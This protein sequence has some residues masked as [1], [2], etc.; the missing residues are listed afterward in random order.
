[1]SDSSDNSCIFIR[2]DER[3]QCK[4][5]NCI[6]GTGYIVH[7]EECDAYGLKA[8]NG[9]RKETYLVDG[10]G[11]KGSAILTYILEKGHTH[12]QCGIPDRDSKFTINSVLDQRSQMYWFVDPSCGTNRHKHEPIGCE[13]GPFGVKLLK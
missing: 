7:T 6:G 9:K 5:C 1:M 13:V 2:D 4:Y 10:S 11:N 8:G 12:G 3:L